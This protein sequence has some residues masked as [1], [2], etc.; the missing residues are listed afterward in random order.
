[1]SHRRL[2]SNSHL[3]LVELDRSVRAAVICVAEQTLWRVRRN[4]LLSPFELC[5]LIIQ[6][7][8]HV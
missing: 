6:Y 3:H 8:R 2:V 4:G 1:M 5:N 7:Q